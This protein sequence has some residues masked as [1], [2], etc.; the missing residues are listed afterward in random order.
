MGGWVGGKLA[1]LRWRSRRD[2]L[3]SGVRD[4]SAREK[5]VGTMGEHDPAEVPDEGKSLCVQVSK[6]RVGA[7]AAH[8][9]GH[10]AAEEGHGATGAEAAGIDIVWGEAQGE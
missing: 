6:H 1:V 9:A 8:Q 2:D 3:R 4:V 5:G 7:P 10:A